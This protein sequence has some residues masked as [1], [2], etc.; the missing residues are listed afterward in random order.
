MLQ[1]TEFDAI[2]C[3]RTTVSG[4]G[5]KL[6]VY[7]YFMDGL[8]VDTGPSRMSR[9]LIPFFQD[10]PIEQVVLTHHHEDHT[11]LARW[12]EQNLGMTPYIHEKGI[13]LCQQRPSLPL[14][15]RLFWGGREPFQPQPVPS[16]VETEHYQFEVIHTPGHADDHISLLN[17]EQGWLF[18]GD[19]FVTSRPKSFFSFEAAPQIIRSLRS[20]LSYDFSTL[21]CSHAGVLFDGKKMIQTKLNYLEEVVGQVTALYEQGLTAKQIRQRLFPQI[22]PMQLLSGFENSPEHLIRSIVRELEVERNQP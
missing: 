6:D 22:H 19:L 7:L 5:I 18:S 3:A 10:K 12:I 21:I 1:I 16:T 20:I 15:R 11:G 17:R 2:T 13:P 9:T 4:G 14:Y 8:L